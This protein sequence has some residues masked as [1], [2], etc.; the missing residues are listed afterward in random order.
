MNVCKSIVE[1]VEEFWK[2][3]HRLDLKYMEEFEVL[4]IYATFLQQSHVYI[5]KVEF[6]I[7]ACI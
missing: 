5:L 1:Y 6:P 2:L 3:S 4:K 7:C